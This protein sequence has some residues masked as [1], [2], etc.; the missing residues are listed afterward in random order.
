MTS[1]LPFLAALLTTLL[2]AGAA[3]AAPILMNPGSIEIENLNGPDDF[4]ITYDGGDTSDNVLNFTAEGP[5]N[6]GAGVMLVVF[7]GVDIVSAGD[8]VG[9]FFNPDNVITGLPLLDTP[10]AAALLLDVGSP[11]DESFFLGLSGTPTLAT[12]YS[13]AGIDFRRFS[14]LSKDDLAK[15][16]HGLVEKQKIEFTVDGVVVPEPSAALVFGVGLLVTS[17]AIRRRR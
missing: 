17:Q 13:I 7:D 2:F 9:G 5:G 10:I 4:V 6:F 8:T 1:R 3:S 14:Q 12:V 11:S 15:L 16:I